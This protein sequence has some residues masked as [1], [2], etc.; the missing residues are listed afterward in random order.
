MNLDVRGIVW[1]LSLYA[2]GLPLNHHLLSPVK[3]DLTGFPPILIQVGDAEVLF[4]DSEHFFTNAVHA[5]ISVK[6]DVYEDMFHVFQVFNFLPESKYS[7]SKI[8]NFIKMLVANQSFDNDEQVT[9][10]R[11]I[12]GGFSEV[13]DVVVGNISQTQRRKSNNLQEFSLDSFLYIF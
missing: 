13:V 11:K 3:M 2:N 5:G 10:I 7:L 1:A 9:I 6:L 12:N 8:G 4:N